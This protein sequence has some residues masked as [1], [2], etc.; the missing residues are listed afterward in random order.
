MSLAVCRGLVLDTPRDNEELT[1]SEFDHT[2]PQ[3]NRELAL[4]DQEKLVL[5][6]VLMPHEFAFEL[7]KLHVLAIELGDD[8]RALGLVE[9]T[10]LF[11]EIHFLVLAITH[12]R[13]PTIY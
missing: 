4:E 8:T 3:V 1:F 13:R 5:M 6:F 10:E 11:G 9:L 12:F 2:F 7:R